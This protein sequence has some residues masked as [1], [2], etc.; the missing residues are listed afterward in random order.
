M[1]RNA[2]ANLCT[3]FA[4][5]SLAEWW[6]GLGIVTEVVQLWGVFPENQLLLAEFTSLYKGPRRRSLPSAS[7]PVV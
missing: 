7:L 4:S 1:P 3:K 6:P 5:E 2:Q